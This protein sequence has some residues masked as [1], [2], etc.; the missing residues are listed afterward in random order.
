MCLA[1]FMLLFG[2]MT[3][4]AAQSKKSKKVSVIEVKACVTDTDGNPLSNVTV[5]SGEGS[6]TNYTD[7]NGNFT[8]K[9]KAN[10]KLLVEAMGYKDQVINLTTGP[11]PAV[12][13]LEAEGL[14]NSERDAHERGDGGADTYQS[15]L[16]SAIGRINVEHLKA[17]P[18]MRL[19]NT[20]QGQ[21]AG[22]IAI[23]NIGG[24]GYNESE[25][26]IRGQ[27][28]NASN[29]AI[30]IIDGIER[31]IDDII[32]EE[33]ESIEVLK[34]APAKI[35]YGPRATNGVVLVRTKRG[36][37]HKRIIRVGLEYGV[38]ATTR[39][40]KFL[41]SYNYAKLY[42]EAC[43]NDGMLPLY[44]DKD[45]EG[46]RNS[47]GVNDLLYPNVDYYKTFVG[48]QSTYRKAT[49][50][51]NG[52][53]DNVTYAVTVG[54]TGGSGLEAV[55]DRQDLNRVNARGNL[56]IRV[57]SF[58]SVIADVAARIQKKDW[59][60]VDG[61]TMFGAISTLR[62]NEYPFMINPEDINGKDGIAVDDSNPIFGASS[63]KTNNLYAQMAY[64]GNSSER[65]V[66]S[67]TN[68]GLDF[69][70]NEFV[71]GLSAEAYMT[72][73]NYSYLRQSLTNKYQTF[74]IDR[75]LDDN[76]EEVIRFTQR[77]QLNL[78]KKQ[79]IGDNDTYRNFGWRANVSYVKSFGDHDFAANVAYRYFKEEMTGNSQDIKNDNFTLRLN[80]DY[81][82]RYFLEGTLS[83]MGSNRFEKG[84]RYFMGYSIG[85]AWVLSNED[86]LSG[87]DNVNFLKLKASYGRLGYDGNTGYFLWRTNWAK[88]DTFEFKP[89]T[90]ATTTTF[91]RW[92]N[93]G[94]NWEHSNEFNVGIEGLFF[95]NRLSAEVNY[96]REMRKDI[97]ALNTSK[98]S[99]VGGD[100]ILP[101]NLG[102]VLNQGV[103]AYVAWN[104]K[105]GKDFTYNVGL[106]VTYTKNELRKWNEL[107][108]IEEYRK[109]VGKPTSTLFGL[110]SQGL[111]GK[112]VALDGH[113]HQAFG[114]YQV[115]DIAYADMND[116]NIVDDNDKASLG[117]SFPTTTLGIDITL[118][119]K[120]IGLYILGTAT[121]GVTKLCNNA[122]YWNNGLDGYSTLALDRYHPV[123]NPTGTQPRLTTTD[124]ANNFRNS[125]FWAEDASFFRLKNVELSYTL[126][127]KSGKGLGK[128]YK[129]FVRGTNLFVLSAVKDLDPEMLNGGV[130][131][132]P[133]YRTVTGGVSITF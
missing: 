97:I 33:I 30:V 49:L 107:G 77:Q 56:N 114:N 67:Q 119:Y 27:H 8:I 43:E 55:G 93:P 2:D 50:E 83:A 98:H 47:T 28:S 57:N 112:D 70:L 9:T 19:S 10:G 86:F 100:F 39:Q 80:Y 16:T 34:D 46:Y 23:A 69:N 66:N 99:A 41:D 75:Y 25:L 101:E 132:Y 133:A 82:N 103:D 72:F 120:G 121:T 11:C 48:D 20:L 126:T 91:T 122:Y 73:D 108:N 5:L 17:M 1:A 106:N 22:L 90:G 76:N 118:N 29:Q 60:A 89:S 18:D 102:E 64:G 127:N 88:G 104:G 113:V 130:T 129:F 6:I 79:T 81:N 3:D 4:A 85:A 62:P 94:L 117:Q 15:G 32:P 123:N 68:I 21:A 78:P 38:Q 111:F 37:A 105:S 24:L 63:R 51:L 116:D 36:E 52:G 96:F 128:N 65:Y 74:S 26:Y 95:K 31:P 12:I 54:Y 45:L 92:G 115:G 84:N 109:S 71:E 44:S 40:P 58:L 53:N 125:T 110:Q 59:G 124:G 13:E 7:N 14:Y 42:N 35:L 61:A 87:S 131:N